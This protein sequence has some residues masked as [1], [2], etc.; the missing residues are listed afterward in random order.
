MRPTRL[1]PTLLL[2]AVVAACGGATSAEDPVPASDATSDVAAT[3][4]LVDTGQTVCYGVSGG[5]VACGSA[6]GGQDAEYATNPPRYT[7][8]GDGTV[9]DNVTG[10]MWESAYR[11]KMSLDDALAA[12]SSIATGGYADWRVPS[13]KELYSLIDFSGATGQ[14]ASS[15]TPY[16]D[17]SVFSFAYGD[18]A[19]GE[20]YI[21]AQ[22]L[23]ST[24]YVATTMNGDATVFGVNFA[25]GRI[26]GYPRYANAGG[27][28]GSQFVRFV[29]GSAYGVNGLVDNGDETVTDTAAGLIWAKSDGGPYDWPGALSYCENLSLAGADDWRLP[30]AKQLQSIV[31]YS[32]SPDTTGSAA[33]DPVFDATTIANEGG[34]S[35]Y[36]FY[37]SSTTHLDGAPETLGDHA[38]YVSFGRALGLWQGSYVDVHGAGAQRSDPK[39]GNAADYNPSNA[40]QGDVVRID[41]YARCVRTP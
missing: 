19:A 26:K 9:T 25:D 33:I 14:S 32:R 38:V 28:G 23:S 31:D 30:D 10:L 24:T 21:D 41:N 6:Y 37:W 13:I 11:G 7:A 4:T 17:T 1:V 16:I 27:A 18:T 29:R 8:N 35:D 22:Y 12:A 20:R 34:G 3:F 2:L 5:A 36:P 39:T 15:A 40:P